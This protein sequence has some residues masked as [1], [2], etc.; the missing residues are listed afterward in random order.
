MGVLYQAESEMEKRTLSGADVGR[1]QPHNP[2]GRPGTGMHSSVRTTDRASL[3]KQNDHFLSPLHPLQNPGCPQHEMSQKNKE[4][5]GKPR[6]N[7]TG[8]LW[9]G[10]GLFPGCVGHSD[11]P[12]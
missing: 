10:D 9:P 4:K 1:V 7:K 2:Q 6:G 11:A 5:N 3:R 8:S 12:P